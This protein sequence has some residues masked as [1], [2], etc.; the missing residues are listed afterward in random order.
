MKP[1]SLLL[2]PCGAA[3][4]LGCRYCFYSGHASG[5]IS[6]ETLARTL[7]SYCAL[8]FPAAEKSVALQGGEPLLAPDYVF[9]EMEVRALSRSLQTNATLLTRE[10]A[11]RLARGNWLVGVSVDGPPEIHDAVRSSSFAAVESGIRLLEEAG[12]DYNLL[13]VVSAANISRPE[14][15]YRFLKGRFATRFHQYV[16]CTGPDPSL[17]IGGDE[18]GE[19]LVRLFDEWIGEDAHTVSVRLFDSIVSQLVHGF[20]TQ[21][22]FAET[23][24]QYLVV[25]HDGSVYP[26]DFHVR[27][28]LKL[29]N[30]LTHAWEEMLSSPVYAR[31]AAA[32]TEALP[33]EC[34]ECEYFAFCRGDCPRNRRSLCAGWRRFFAHAVPRLAEL[35]ASSG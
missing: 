26:C 13:T 19:F 2:K 23:C 34:R 24:R 25:E 7:D 32:K 22:S 12:A 17:A 15:V 11:E 4:N 3:C 20:P 27:P 6:R 28:D 21:C 35:V 9:D 10:T 14:E 8:P 16:E 29:G 1:F 33:R 30:V 18:W 5:V 31:F